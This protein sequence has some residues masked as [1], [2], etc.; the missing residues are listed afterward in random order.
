MSCWPI[1][2]VV[3]FLPLV[4]ALFILMVRGDDQVAVRNIRWTALWTTIITFLSRC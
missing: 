4:G 1:L 3:T 2:S